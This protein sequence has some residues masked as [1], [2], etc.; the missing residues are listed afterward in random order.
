MTKKL[1]W[2]GVAIMST[3]LVLV[4]LW[5][6]RNPVVYLLVSLALAA[7]VRPVVKR[8][9][10][11]GFIVRLALIF[12]F[13]VSLGSFGFLF[14]LGGGSALSEIN[15]LAK[16]V[17]VQDEWMLPEWLGNSIR[18]PLAERL[19]SPSELFTAFTGDQGQLVLPAILGFTR[20]IAGLVSGVLVILFLSFYWSL[21][22]VHFERLWLSLLQPGQR[23]RARNIWQTIEADLGV[24][25]RSQ[26]V[27]SLL[28]GLLLGLGYWALGSPYPTLLGL[29]GALAY[30]IPMV[31]VGMAVVL[32]LSIGLLA[33]VQL[34][35][36][37]ALYTLVVLIVL[38]VWV[39]PRLFNH[40]QYNPILTVVILIA[41]AKSFG[42]IGIIAAPPLSAAIQILWSRLVVHR[43]V[44]GSVSQLSDLQERYILLRTAVQAMN[45]PPSPLVTSSME[46]LT[47]LIEK[48]QPVLL[49]DLPAELSEGS[50]FE[51]PQLVEINI[52]SQAD[53]PEGSIS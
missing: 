51:I 39:K 47:R 45:E 31:G 35:L 20:G 43:M 40:R 18:L 24:Y 13:V 28:A 26:V 21:N 46:R 44:P 34:G 33:S 11:Q 2:F 25:I 50:N 22:Q 32:P 38:E 49:E 8:W 52:P 27:L 48:A 15:Q 5:Q 17:A 7:A 41:M 42:F 6:F 14:V 3:L 10:R 53:V 30:L 12:L 4:I 9:G 16:T 23:N 1:V 29:T 36:S 37:T 19:P